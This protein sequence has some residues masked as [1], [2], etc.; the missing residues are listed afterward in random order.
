M[1][2]LA[3]SSLQSQIDVLER[4]LKLKKA[5]ASV[6]FSL[7]GF[8][9]DVTDEVINSMKNFADAKASEGSALTSDVT[10]V[11]STEEIG[12]LRLLAA[13]LLKKSAVPVIERTT[14]KAFNVSAPATK[15][16]VG[17]DCELLQTLNVPR[18]YR[19]T[20]TPEARMRILGVNVEGTKYQLSDLQGA[21]FWL[22]E[23]D[24][25]IIEN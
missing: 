19:N 22:P 16:P 20:I 25:S 21:T 1:E 4:Q 9:D 5:Y 7:K 12:A 24:V 11:F 14:A 15:G 6:K 18:P 17:K 3:S 2:L 10:T 13:S 23:E 8:P